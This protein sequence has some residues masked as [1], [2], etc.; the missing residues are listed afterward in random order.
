MKF[1]P[2]PR[3]GRGKFFSEIQVQILFRH[4]EHRRGGR[5]KSMR[6]RAAENTM[7]RRRLY[8]LAPHCISISYARRSYWCS[9]IIG[10]HETMPAG[11]A[12]LWAAISLVRL[13]IVVG[14][15]R[16]GRRSNGSVRHA[17]SDRSRRRV[18][19]RHGDDRAHLCVR[20]DLRRERS[21]RRG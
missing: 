2:L 10:S 20:R 18:R 12:A 16:R 7:G 5:K 1:L 8:I 19:L 6:I 13:P 11:F 3:R 9:E 4:R 21:R 14:P 17:C 15:S